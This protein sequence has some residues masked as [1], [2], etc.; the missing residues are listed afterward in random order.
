MLSVQRCH[1]TSQLL[2][3]LPQRWGGHI[4]GRSHISEENER[5]GRVDSQNRPTGRNILLCVL[6]RQHTGQ[7]YYNAVFYVHKNIPCY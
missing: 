5:R 3:G 2:S 6:I 1:W 4:V 7:P